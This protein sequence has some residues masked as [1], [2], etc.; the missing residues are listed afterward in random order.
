MGTDSGPATLTNG[1]GPTPGNL[2]RTYNTENAIYNLEAVSLTLDPFA[3]KSKAKV[4][5]S[6]DARNSELGWNNVSASSRAVSG[7]IDT[8][9]IDGVPGQVGGFVEFLWTVTGSSTISLDPALQGDGTPPRG[10]PRQGR[11]RR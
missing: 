1:E 7:L 10:A 8:A 2:D 4:E 5:V 11:R 3:L 6:I 9:F